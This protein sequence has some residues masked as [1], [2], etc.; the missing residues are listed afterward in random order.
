MTRALALMVLVLGVL[1][2]ADAQCESPEY[3]TTCLQTARNKDLNL[4]CQEACEYVSFSTLFSKPSNRTSLTHI[5][6]HA[7]RPTTPY[8]TCPGHDQV[9]LRL[10]T[11]SL[12]P[13]PPSRPSSSP[14]AVHFANVLHR[15]S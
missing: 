6:R 1:R 12:A 8:R 15:F 11:S 7:R 3:L 10:L 4:R 13:S 2:L 14:Y 5:L 9:P